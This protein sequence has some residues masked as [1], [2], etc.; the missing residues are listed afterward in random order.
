LD[1]KNK[2]KEIYLVLQQG[3]GKAIVTNNYSSSE[4]DNI[5]KN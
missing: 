5:I 3:I 4:L 1:K 2:N